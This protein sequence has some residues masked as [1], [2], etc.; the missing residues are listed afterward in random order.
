MVVWS[1][2]VNLYSKVLSMVSLGQCTRNGALINM[3]NAEESTEGQGA[4]LGGT[5]GSD[6]AV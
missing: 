6:S 2:R 4:E 1:L 3:I 5:R